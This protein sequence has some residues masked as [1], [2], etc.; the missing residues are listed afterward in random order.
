MSVYA[1]HPHWTSTKIPFR[2]FPQFLQPVAD[3]D[4]GPA[5]Y[6]LSRTRTKF[7]ERGFFYSGPATW[8]TLPS[9]L[10]DITDTSTFRKRLKMYFLIVLSTDFCWRSWTSRIAMFGPGLRLTFLRCCARCLNHA[11]LRM[12]LSFIVKWSCS[13]RIYDTLIIC[14]YNN[15]N[16]KLLSYRRERSRCRVG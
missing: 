11:S 3:I 5:A 12:R 7:D 4:S 8:N 6:V 13:H 10:H 15:N 14:V 16:N 9:D 1:L 2:L